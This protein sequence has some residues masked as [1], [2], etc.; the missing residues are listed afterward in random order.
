MRHEGDFD[1]RF[2]AGNDDVLR[3][4]YHRF[5]RSVH[6][7]AA[8]QLAN[9]SDAEDVTQAVFVA[10]WQRRA[11]FDPDRGTLPA[12]L[13]GITRRKII[14]HLRERGRQIRNSEAASQVVSSGNADDTDRLVQRLVL[15]DAIG[16]L[17]DAERRLLTLA[18]YNDLSHQQIATAT[19]LPLGTVKSHL[20]RGL[21]RLRHQ[22]EMDG[23]LRPAHAAAC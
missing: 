10:A 4:A 9:P 15:A 7:L 5:A 3:E 22:W 1:E 11:T 17:P 13:M 8:A 16:R 21:A 12:W 2:R 19:N 18:F 6:H 23:A 14:D 20:R